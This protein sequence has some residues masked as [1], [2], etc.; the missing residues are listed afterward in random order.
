MHDCSRFLDELNECASG[1]SSQTNL[2]LEILALRLFF[3]VPVDP[4]TQLA[5]PQE[6]GEG[7]RFMPVFPDKVTLEHYQADHPTLELVTVR[8]KASE[9][10]DWA[11]K[12]RLGVEVNVY[13]DRTN[14]RQVFIPYMDV[15]ALARGKL[16]M[17]LSPD[18]ESQTNA[19]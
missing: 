2:Y 19:L 3:L 4:F 12:L 14:P 15:E 18:H 10:F 17:S 11:A 5:R 6:R 1:N 13:L 7:T 9:F 16:P 8:V